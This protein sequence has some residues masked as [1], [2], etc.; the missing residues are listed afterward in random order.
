LDLGAGVKFTGKAQEALA[1]V[2]FAY[3]E[4][5]DLVEWRNVCDRMLQLRDALRLKKV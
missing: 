2:G 1:R 5:F 4:R 3:A